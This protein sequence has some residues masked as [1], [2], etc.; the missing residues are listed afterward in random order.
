MVPATTGEVSEYPELKTKTISPE[1]TSAI[2]GWLKKSQ[3]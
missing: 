2:V 3:P 1:V